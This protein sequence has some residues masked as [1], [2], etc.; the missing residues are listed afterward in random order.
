MK[1]INRLPSGGIWMMLGL[2]LL[3]AALG[4]TAYN[5]WD[6]RRAQASVDQA[7]IRLET[8]LPQIQEQ[9]QEMTENVPETV[10]PDEELPDYVRYPEMDMPTVSVDGVEYLGTLE[11]PVLSLTLPVIQEWSYPLLRLAPCRYSGSVY[12]E[13][14]VI[15]GHNYGGHFGQLKTLQAGD[16]V[17]FTDAAGNCF[18]YSVTA[19]E[20]LEATAV[21]DMEAGEW[22]LT[23]FTCTVGGQSRLAV[24][25]DATE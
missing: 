18:A 25:C 4:L 9:E 5:L 12:L 3:L 2:L 17:R 14:L 1:Q 20:V 13:N 7:L 10:V 6:E 8:V 21:E 16:E 15:C 22:D 24:R 23:L 19:M 11:V